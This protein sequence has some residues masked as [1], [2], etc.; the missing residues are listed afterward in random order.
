VLPEEGAGD[1]FTTSLARTFAALRRDG[2]LKPGDVALVV[3]VA[4]GLQVG[5]ALYY[6]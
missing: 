6:G 2:R 3:E 1:P 4:A 5:C